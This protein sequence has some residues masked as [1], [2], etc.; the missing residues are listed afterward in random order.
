MG[1]HRMP[2]LAKCGKI[3]IVIR[4]HML[5]NIAT[6]PRPIRPHNQLGSSES[7]TFVSQWHQLSKH[8]QCPLLT[9][10]SSQRTSLFVRRLRNCASRCSRLSNPQH[11][12]EGIPNRYCSLTNR[13]RGER[14]CKC[15]RRKRLD[16]SQQKYARAVRLGHNCACKIPK[17]TTVL[18]NRQGM[19][20]R[21]R[22]FQ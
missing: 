14:L 16:E 18:G 17:T 11:N 5:R 13:Q 9:L 15:F 19:S 1:H 21:C 20:V 10:Q 6:M 22:C 2:R 8:M 7:C 12:P 4:S 3:L